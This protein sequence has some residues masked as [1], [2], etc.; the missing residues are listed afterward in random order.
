MVR[1]RADEGKVK[2]QKRPHEGAGGLGFDAL[3]VAGGIERPQSEG[4]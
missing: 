3:V 1:K 4:A 2:D